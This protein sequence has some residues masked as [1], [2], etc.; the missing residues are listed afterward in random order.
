MTVETF[1]KVKNFSY[2]YTMGIAYDDDELLMR[3]RKMG[4]SIKIIDKPFV[5]HQWHYSSNAYKGLNT[6]ELI[7]KNENLLRNVCQ[8]E[9]NYRVNEN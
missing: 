7:K 9:T 8:H 6:S 3:I 5:I 2:D 4:L 1:N